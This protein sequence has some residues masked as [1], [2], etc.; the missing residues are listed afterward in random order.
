MR[1][2]SVVILAT[3]AF[4]APA[5]ANPSVPE[6]RQPSGSGSGPEFGT[7]RLTQRQLAERDYGDAYNEIA[8]AKKDV[9]AAK[10]GSAAKRYRKAR[11]RAQRAVE[12][13]S[14]YHEAWNLLGYSARKLG[15]HDA[16]IAAYTKCLGIQYD[17]A[18]AREYLGEAYLEIGKPDKA[19]AQLAIL[20]K[21]GATAEAPG[22]RAAV[23]AWVAA[24]P[25]EPAAADSG[26]A[27]GR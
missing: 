27:A 22:L 13:D 15:D 5:F 20:D 10:A 3:L 21:L 2:G 7:T 14:T 8:K 6:P 9:A 24:H 17:Y 26:S 19:R 1:L 16:A 4:A 23:D 11:E 12:T 18:P 25:A